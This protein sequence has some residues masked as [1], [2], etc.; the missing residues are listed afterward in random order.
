MADI[1]L[2]VYVGLGL[3]IIPEILGRLLDML[4]VADCGVPLSS[5]SLAVAV[6][7]ILD[8]C[9]NGPERMELVL[10]CGTP[11]IDHS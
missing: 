5:A 11:S 4:V 7:V 6:Q 8:G 1:V 2:L 10:L 3:R 9:E